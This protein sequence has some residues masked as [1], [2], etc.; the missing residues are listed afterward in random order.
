MTLRVGYIA[1]DYCSSLVLEE[2]RE[3]RRK[4][5]SQAASAL[6][7]IATAGAKRVAKSLAKSSTRG[8][9]RAVTGMGGAVQDAGTSMAD[10]LKWSG[11]EETGE[12]ET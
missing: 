4:A 10:K 8:V 9:R 2:R 7:S 5:V 6:G 3:R 1:R 11:G 12:S